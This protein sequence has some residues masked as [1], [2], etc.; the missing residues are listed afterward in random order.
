M[1]IVVIS[2]ES[3]GRIACA[4]HVPDE[5]RRQRRGVA[6]H[7]VAAH[8]GQPVQVDAEDQHQHH[9][10]PEVGHRR[11]D[12]EHRRQ[13]AVKPPAPA[14][15]GHDAEPGAE[16]ERQHRGDADQAKRP[17]DRVADDRVHRRRVEV[18]RRAEVAGDDLVQVVDVLHRQALVG[19]DPEEDL[20]R[21]ERLR[22]E[23]A[24]ELRQHG[25]RRV[26]RHQPRQQE[27][28]C[29]RR[30][31]REEE[32]PQAAQHISHLSG[33]DLSRPAPTWAAGAAAPAPCPGTR[34][35]TAGR[36]GRRRWAIR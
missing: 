2:S 24:V 10:H 3:A 17:P 21:V 31:E 34:T 6:G 35:R 20:Q 32:E 12:H 11:G 36:R 1:P 23:V 25:Q 30:P 16:H 7:V 8:V 33:S 27:V 18:E 4:E 15:G 5:V 14:P 28:E 26:P 9:A 19:V 29:Q 22:G 13:H